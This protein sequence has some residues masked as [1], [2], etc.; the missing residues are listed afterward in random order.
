MN[1]IGVVKAK[2]LPTG[3]IEIYV[4]TTVMK[5]LL[6]DT[7]QTPM[8]PWT[9]GISSS[10]EIYGNRFNLDNE[11][12][13]PYLSL[14]REYKIK[15]W[16]E[17]EVFKSKNV[18][19]LRAKEIES[20]IYFRVPKGKREEAEEWVRKCVGAIKAIYKNRKERGCVCCDCV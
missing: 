17:D 5:D 20:G 11:N 9:R 7:Q 18:S 3:E 1:R 2:R 4:K 14:S 13:Q 15:A 12:H 16:N 6:Q 10:L 8:R 19:I